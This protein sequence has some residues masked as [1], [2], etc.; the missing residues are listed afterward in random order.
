[1]INM[2][3]RVCL[4]MVDSPPRMVVLMG[5]LLMITPFGV[6]SSPM[7]TDSAELLHLLTDLVIPVI[8]CSSVT[9]FGGAWMNICLVLRDLSPKQ[10]YDEL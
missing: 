8:P 10:N 6:D 7:A 5:K 9:S 1:M 3:I 2:H 4:K